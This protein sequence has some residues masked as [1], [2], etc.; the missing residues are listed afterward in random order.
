[1]LSPMTPALPPQAA[2]KPVTHQAHGETRPDDYHWLKTQ[3]RE[4]PEVLAYLKAENAYLEATLAPLKGL[5]EGLYQELLSHVQET[6]QDP[7]VPWGDWLYYRR[8]VEGQQEALYCRKPKDGGPEQVILDP[9]ALKAQLGLEN[10]WVG[11]VRPSP[12]HARL[13]YLLDRAGG[14]R[15]ELRV[16]DLGSGED[17]ASGVRDVSGGSLEW[18]AD[19]SRLYY[20]RNDDAWRAY[21]LCRHRL[22]SDPDTD[23][24]LVQEDDQTFSLSLSLSDSGRELLLTSHS[25][26]TTEVSHLAASNAAG[27][28]E[29]IWPR[30]RG[31]EYG[32]EDGGDHWLITTNRGG[33]RE[34]E[35]LAVPKDG[36][37]PRPVIAHTPTRKLDFVRVFARFLLVAGREDGL[38]QL[39]VLTRKGNTYGEPRRLPAPEPVFTYRVGENHEF[40]AS[41]ARILYSSPVTPLTHLDLDL[42]TLETRLVKRTPVPGY[43]ASL[44]ACERLWVTAQDGARVPVSLVFRKDAARP[45]PTYLYGYGSYGISLDPAFH[46]ARLPLLDRGWVCATAHVRGGGELGRA[47]YEGGKLAEKRRSFSDFIACAEGLIAQGVA[48]PGRIAIEGRSAGGLLMG[49]VL[50]ARPDLFAAAIAGVPF[51]DVLST[52]QDASIPLTTLEYDEWGDPADPQLYAAMRAY[53]PYDN[54]RRGAVYP[55]LYV[56]TGLNDPRVAYWEPAKWVARLRAEADIQRS[57]VL[58]TLLGA[59]HFSSSGRYDALRERAGELAFLIGAL[60]GRLGQLDG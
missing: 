25:T 38:A 21:Q 11:E 33:A 55:H 18:S 13:A 10:L 3:G 20:I 24:L 19:G 4:D 60:E 43:D 56:S 57:L 2:R 58:R 59:G 32:V 14:E 30:E 49:G 1:M 51:V 8:T 44:Y 16:K 48:A 42:A 15:F 27:R 40:E 5:A 54:V 31:V 17:R 45:A 29:I 50:N 35:L 41:T 39:W 28:F 46:A 52:M 9:N 22:G 37:A 7:P 26:T 53:S 34:F 6:D 36:S 12:D 47:W 23:E